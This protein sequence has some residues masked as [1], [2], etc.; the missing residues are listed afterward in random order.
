MVQNGYKF[1]SLQYLLLQSA[2]IFI[3]NPKIHAIKLSGPGLGS[4]IIMPA[5]YFFIE[6]NDFEKRYLVE[7]HF[8]INN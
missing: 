4:H 8:S 6:L 7:M 5:R 1:C 3:L 2:I